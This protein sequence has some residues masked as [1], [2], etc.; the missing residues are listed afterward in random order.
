MS[1]TDRVRVVKGY[2]ERLNEL[3]DAAQQL[4]FQKGYDQTSVNMIIQKVGVA[5]GTFYH[6]FKSKEDLVDR[7]AMRSSDQI[8]AQVMPILERNDLSAL[9]K[10]NGFFAAVRTFKTMAKPLM[11]MLAKV[12]FRDD[13][14]V[15]RHKMRMWSVKRVTPLFTRILEEGKQSGEFNIDSPKHSAE[16]LFSL[17]SAMNENMTEYLIK[18]HTNGHDGPRDPNPL[19]TIMAKI[20]TCQTAIERMLGVD[21]NTIEIADIGYL[22]TFFNDD[23]SFQ[24]IEVPPGA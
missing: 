19:E 11:L 20:K 18:L 5:K 2:D 6:Y 13:N 4:F 7:L 21:E 17:S 22:K 12:L 9:E 16:L 15:L 23:G 10:I 14:L 24:E 3:L 1:Q 8:M